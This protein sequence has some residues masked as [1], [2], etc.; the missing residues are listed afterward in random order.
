MT[1][2]VFWTCN[3]SKTWKFLQPVDINNIDNISSCKSGK[4]MH[5]IWALSSYCQLKMTNLSSDYPYLTFCCFFINLSIMVL[6]KIT[7]YIF[8]FNCSFSKMLM[9][10]LL[11]T[12]FLINSKMVLSFGKGVRKSNLMVSVS[13]ELFA[14]NTTSPLFMFPFLFENFVLFKWRLYFFHVAKQF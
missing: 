2:S 11:S 5:T 8:F 6:A 10:I 7:C 4:V 14:L 3:N 13:L 1:S 12:W 9:G